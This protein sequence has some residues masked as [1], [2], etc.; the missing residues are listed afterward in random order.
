MD[1][2]QPCD[3]IWDLLAAY[4]DGDVT[5]DEARLVERHLARC[6]ECMRAL[7]VLRSVSLE[8]GPEDV[9]DP[10]RDLPARILNAT[11]RVSSRRRDSRWRVAGPRALP[12][13]ASAMAVALLGYVWGGSLHGVVHSPWIPPPQFP[14]HATAPPQLAAQP[15]PP[16]AEPIPVYGAPGDR[17]VWLSR[18]RESPRTTLAVTPTAQSRWTTAEHVRTAAPMAGG[19][20]VEEPTRTLADSAPV[21]ASSDPPADPHP[22]P[23]P[24]PGS[25]LRMAS[26]T[27]VATDA[28]PAVHAPAA[29]GV[30]HLVSSE[31]R[32]GPEMMVSLA[33]LR[34]GLE[35]QDGAESQKSL[36]TEIVRPERREVKVELSLGRF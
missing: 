23:D 7:Q 15:A 2:R 4:A 21:R 33:A 20:T 32:M 30:L 8:L 12:A 10:P 14:A 34:H 11:V 25:E 31:P 22:E 3:G 17:G 9:P 36:M 35:A 16:A 6:P 5:D 19:P 24:A 29:N 1:D 26:R 28:V 27:S 13:L 18:R